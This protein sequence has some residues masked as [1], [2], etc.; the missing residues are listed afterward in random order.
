MSGIPSTVVYT[1]KNCPGC[2][3]L[4]SRLE[5]EGRTFIEME[6][7]KDVTMEAFQLQFPDVRSVPHVVEVGS[8]CG[9][10]SN[11]SCD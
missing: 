4:K 3:A 9:N 8:G 5:S 11:C 6:I 1:K 2:V 7:G 10:C